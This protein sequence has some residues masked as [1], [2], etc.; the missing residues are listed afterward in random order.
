VKGARRPSPQQA[1]DL[2]HTPVQIL[3]WL[4]GRW[5]MEVTFEEARA[6]LGVETRRQWSDLAI[7]VKVPRSLLE[8][9]T[10]VVCYAA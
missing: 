8:R 10:D 4:V 2:G 7:V 5:R 9:L 6:H 1:L 3:S